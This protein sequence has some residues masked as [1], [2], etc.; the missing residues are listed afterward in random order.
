[1]T[2]TLQSSSGEK[3]KDQIENESKMFEELRKK[4]STKEFVEQYNKGLA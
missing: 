1:M 4:M 2:K 3:T